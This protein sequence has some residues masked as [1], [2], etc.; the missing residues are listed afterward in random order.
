M[1]RAKFD[2]RLMRFYIIA[3]YVI[4]GV[5][6]SAV[7]C[8]NTTTS[9]MQNCVNGN[10][11]RHISD[12]TRVSYFQPDKYYFYA[13]NTTKSDVLFFVCST[14]LCTSSSFYSVLD[15]TS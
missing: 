10:I 7:S 3:M 13:K 11:C 4:I 14:E 15:K 8:T 1:R 5:T 12:A 9:N 2:P 6:A